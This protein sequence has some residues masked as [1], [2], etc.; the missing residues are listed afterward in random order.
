MI[1]IIEK[2]QTFLNMLQIN[3]SSQLP[4]KILAKENA[5]EALAMLEI[6]PDIKLII[7]RKMMGKEETAQKIIDEIKQE[8]YDCKVLVLEQTGQSSEKFV[9]YIETT[10]T[11]DKVSK[12]VI[13]MINSDGSENAPPMVQRNYFTI[14]FSLLKLLDFFPSDFYIKIKKG[15]LNDYLKLYNKDETVDFKSIDSYLEKGA[16]KAYVKKEDGPNTVSKINERFKKIITNSIED[17]KDREQ[18]ESALLDNLSFLGLNKGTLKIAQNSINKIGNDLEKN[19][20]ITSLISEIYNKPGSLRY[21]KSFMT[22]MF[23]NVIAKQESYLD[24]K[25]I[26]SLLTAAFINDYLLERDEHIVIR[27]EEEFNLALLSKETSQIVDHHAEKAANELA[28]INDVNEDTIKIIRQHHGSNSGVGFS[29]ILSTAISN[30]SKIFILAE[31]LSL[32]ILSA[33]A[34][35]VNINTIL[36]EISTQ[37]QNKLDPFIDH[38]KSSLTSGDQ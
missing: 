32:R 23:C 31:E 34:G 17:L 28:K 25:M 14:P 10:S 11:I 2:D 22:A 29:N 19:K 33:Q 37:Y 12:M 20:K 30:L 1:I 38:L 35:S 18:V 16:K 6:L 21:R 9:R 36:R 8:K 24:S 3:I 26:E 5:A 13:S 27:T 15:D 4:M 7:C